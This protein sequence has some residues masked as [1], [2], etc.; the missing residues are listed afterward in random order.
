MTRGDT[1]PWLAGAAA[2][3]LCL[4]CGGSAAPTE[5]LVT[6][7]AAKVEKAKRYIADG[8][9]ERADLA[10]RQAL[11]DAELAIA[12]ARQEEMKQKADAA[13]LKVERL[14]AG[15]PL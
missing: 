13:K 1:R 14:K 11:A 2:A 15:R 8:M 3:V 12:L 7:E 10:L 4:A 9:N 5:R 6:A